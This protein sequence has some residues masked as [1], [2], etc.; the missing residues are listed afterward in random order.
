MTPEGAPLFTQGT[1]LAEEFAE[2][3][4]GMGENEKVCEDEFLGGLSDWWRKGGKGCGLTVG[5]CRLLRNIILVR[6]RARICRRRWRGLGRRRLCW[7][8]SLLT[9]Y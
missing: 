1:E 4:E 8:V 2:L 7:L 3:V 6:L 5:G 9:S